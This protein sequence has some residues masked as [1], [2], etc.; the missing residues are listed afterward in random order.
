L[1]G[2]H[3]RVLKVLSQ[4]W[5]QS[6]DDLDGCPFISPS[7]ICAEFYEKHELAVGLDASSVRAYLAQLN[8]LIRAATPT[9]TAAPKTHESRR[10]LGYR[11]VEK[12]EI[13]SS[14]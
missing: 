1:A 13:S 3:A 7:Q 12:L 9:G 6:P 10:L 14:G 11:L 5:R 2:R 8:R 4:H